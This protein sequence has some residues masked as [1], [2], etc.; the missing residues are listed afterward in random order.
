MDPQW[1]TLA[2]L[3][4]ARVAEQI[5]SGTLKAVSPWLTPADAAAYLGLRPVSLEQMRAKGTGP[6]FRKIRGRIVRYH[7]RELDDWLNSG[8][9]EAEPA[10]GA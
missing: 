9:A 8:A 6:K 3:V 1:S 10:E 2:D 5:T 4:A 7:V